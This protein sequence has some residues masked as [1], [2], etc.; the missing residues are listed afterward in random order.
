MLF[1]F[2]IKQYLSLSNGIYELFDY[3]KYPQHVKNLF[4]YAFKPIIIQEAL[5]E[6]GFVFWVDTSFRIRHNKAFQ[7]QILFDQARTE[8]GFKI[9]QQKRTLYCFVHAGMY[10]YFNTDVTLYREKE[11]RGVHGGA[12][13]M[14]NNQFTQLHNHSMDDLCPD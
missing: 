9:W 4:N 10:E 2:Q 5:Q 13:M 1:H 11:Y 12:I 14:Y 3:N 7:L 8:R 6:F